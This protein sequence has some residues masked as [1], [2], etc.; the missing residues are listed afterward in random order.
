MLETIHL[1]G[2]QLQHWAKQANAWIANRK[3]RRMNT[4]SQAAGA[5]IEVVADQCPLATLV[6]LSFGRERQRAR[7]NGERAVEIEEVKQ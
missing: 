7:R 4:D 3:L 1:R 6:E 2:N 5:G